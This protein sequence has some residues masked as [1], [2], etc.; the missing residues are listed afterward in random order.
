MKIVIAGS[1]PGPQQVLARTVESLGHEALLA[2]LG[3]ALHVLR[4]S[5]AEALVTDSLELCR[6]VHESPTLYAYCVL[7]AP[8]FD[9]DRVKQGLSMGA[10]DYLVEPVGQAELE[11]R[12]L[13]AER[14]SGLH[15]LLAEQQGELEHLQRELRSSAGIDRLTGVHTKGRLEDDLVALHGRVMRYGHSYCLA[16]FDLDKFTAYNRSLGLEAGDRALGQVG[17]VLSAAVRSG[18]AVYRIAGDRFACIFPEQA[19]EQAFIAVERLR[20]TVEDLAISHP[21]NPP[22]A[23]LTASSG[24][25]TLRPG[26]DRLSG[27]LLEEAELAVNEAKER[28]G[29]RTVAAR[30][31]TV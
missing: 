9:H 18:D 29:N 27:A 23:V 28:G 25:T 13:A 16:L 3:A 30:S 21:D 4:S 2:D 5:A 17:A 6:R 1:D 20:R 19:I 7:L 31:V 8:Q 11:L 26:D 12:L 22:F 14:A 24:I 10:D 15:R